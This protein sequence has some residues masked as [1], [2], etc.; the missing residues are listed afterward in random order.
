MY[1]EGK[2]V[3]AAPSKME[4][5]NAMS[6]SGFKVHDMRRVRLN[7]KPRVIT[8]PVEFVQHVE[9]RT[10]DLDGPYFADLTVYY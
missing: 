6:V 10:V 8:N 9:S 7:G 4:N 1:L 2:A 5:V 3:I